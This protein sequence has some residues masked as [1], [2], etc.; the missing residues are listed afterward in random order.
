MSDRQTEVIKTSQKCWKVL[1]VIDNLH[2]LIPCDVMINIVAE[3]FN[4]YK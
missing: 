4:L 2:T 3:L 1:K